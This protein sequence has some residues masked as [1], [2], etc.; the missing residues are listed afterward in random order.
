M[1]NKIVVTVLDNFIFFLNFIKGIKNF[2]EINLFKE[3]IDDEILDEILK[4][5]EIECSTE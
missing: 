5:E 4:E 1:L 2:I 3:K